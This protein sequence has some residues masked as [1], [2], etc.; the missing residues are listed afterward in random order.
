MYRVK[1]LLPK[2]TTEYLEETLECSPRELELVALAGKKVEGG[3]FLRASSGR[4]I[5]VFLYSTHY[6]MQPQVGFAK[7][8]E[9]N[10]TCRFDASG[11]SAGQQVRGQLVLLT[12]AGQLQVPF[13]V[14]ITDSYE[15]EQ[16]GSIRNLFHFTNLASSNWQTALQLFYSDRMEKLLRGHDSS[17]LPLYRGLS[18]VP[19]SRKNVDEFLISLNKKKRATFFMEDDTLLLPQVYEAQQQV[20]TIHRK[21]WGYSDLHVRCEGRYLT[22]EKTHLTEEDFVD[23]ICHLTF[24][25]LPTDGFEQREKLI[26]ET[27]APSGTMV[28]ELV[29]IGKSKKENPREKQQKERKHQTALLMRAYLDYATGFR[30][31][32]EA[33][34][35]AEKCIDQI[36]KTDG[37]NIAGRMYQTRLLCLMNRFQEAGW[38]FSHVERMVEKEEVSPE[39]MA[40]YWYLQTVLSDGTSA[41]I[42]ERLHQSVV[43]RLRDLL[44]NQ[45]RNPVIT[46]LYLRLLPQGQLTGVKKLSL[47]EE[48]C[49]GGCDSPLLYLE[50]FSVIAENPSYLT[51]LGRFEISVLNFA[52][53]NDLLTESMEIRVIDLVK[54]Q[55]ETRRDLL[56]FLWKMYQGYQEDDL[57]QAVCGLLI[58]CGKCDK[59]SLVWFRR[60]VDKQLRITMLYESYMISRGLTDI[61]LPPKYVLMYFAYQNNLDKVYKA[62]LYRVVLEHHTRLGALID[63]YDPQIIDFAKECLAA[64]ELSCD[65]AYCYRFLLKDEK[66]VESALP[67]LG[68]IAFY[69]QAAVTD[70]NMKELIVIERGLERERKFPIIDGI[71][72]AEIFTEEYTV[73]LQDE[74]GARYSAKNQIKLKRILSTELV[75]RCLPIMEGG[76]VGLSLVRLSLAPD[77]FMRQ[78][79]DLPRYVEATRD[80]E[81]SLPLRLSILDRLMRVLYERDETE[82][83]S[84]LLLEYPIEGADEKKRG[85]IIAYHIGLEQD[86]EALSL[87]WEYGFEGVPPKS[88]NRLIRRGIENSVDGDPKWL[89]LGYYTYKQGKYTQELMQYLCNFYEGGIQQMM[90]IFQ[91]AENFEVDATPIAERILIASTFSHGY[92]PSFD[93]LFRSYSQGGGSSEMKRRFLQDLCYRYFVG[94]EVISESSM[95]ILCSVLAEDDQMPQLTAQTYLM[96][97]SQKEEDFNDKEKMLIEYLVRKQMRDGGYLPFFERFASFIPL[98]LPYAARTWLV[99]RGVPGRGVTVSFLAQGSADGTYQMRPLKEV[100]PGYYTRDFVLYFGDTV[101][102]YIQ[103]EADGDVVLTE[104]GRIEQDKLLGSDNG[105]RFEMKYAI[106]VERSMGDENVAAR[107][108]REYLRKEKLAE[109]LF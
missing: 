97:A 6:R 92:L 36:N 30:D 50:A 46:A 83:L 11:L 4:R 90:Q 75:S 98:L 105:G 66:Q 53:K 109:K 26:V 19:G 23:N 56:S 100:C 35:R 5:Q 7:G 13:S 17:L 31:R 82:A 41:Q 55:K 69:Y 1:S 99:Y 21:G 43:R 14:E 94:G 15:D 76:G 108:E 62:H 27:D 91:E 71:A 89:A 16:L 37:H 101:Q 86:E 48:C 78:T 45:R 70:E 68:S 57:L 87:L 67:Y 93:Q 65:L 59:E 29:R 22:V 9:I 47:Y 28:C 25:L 2:E 58:R 3:L 74:K 81:L 85:Q 88:L 54:R 49:Y 18:A 73:L 12:D 34:R 84:E 103:E 60:A 44:A 96:L 64:G 10:V 32:G 106:A 63:L 95:Q 104:S 39:L 33:L 79:E 8:E 107:I 72:M 51:G 61:S 24:Y 38:I 40:Y 77:E 102:Y 20:L 42:D 80:P 52:L